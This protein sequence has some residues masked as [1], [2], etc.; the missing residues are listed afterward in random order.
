[1]N[2]NL[3]AWIV[4]CDD[5]S[6][7]VAQLV[8]L[9]EIDETEYAMRMVVGGNGYVCLGGRGGSRKGRSNMESQPD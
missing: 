1:M 6:V 9:Y 7:S 5:S 3:V 4:P 8:A 2:C